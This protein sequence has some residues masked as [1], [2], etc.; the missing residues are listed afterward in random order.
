MESGLVCIQ[1]SS[2]FIYE[3]ELQKEAQPA[4]SKG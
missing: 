1:V 4:G 2:L 3:I